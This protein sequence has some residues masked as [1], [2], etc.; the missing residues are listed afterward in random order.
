LDW[1][2]V[3]IYDDNHSRIAEAFNA[4]KAGAFPFERMALVYHS[5]SIDGYREAYRFASN[6]KAPNLIFNHLYIPGDART[7]SERDA[8]ANEYDALCEAIRAEG[9]LRLYAHP[10]YRS[11][12]GTTPRCGQAMSLVSL[13]PDRTLGPCCHLPP[14]PAFGTLEEPSPVL[15][16]KRNVFEQTCPSACERCYFLHGAV[17]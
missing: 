14:G 16:F 10:A 8:F 6:A 2:N 7:D 12:H 4:A 13:A 9:R 1:L 5:G 3:S 15:R 11:T 17:Y